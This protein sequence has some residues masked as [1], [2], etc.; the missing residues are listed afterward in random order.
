M[1]SCVGTIAD[2][3]ALSSLTLNK[4]NQNA[5]DSFKGLLSATA[6]SHD[7]IEL[8]FDAAAGD[9]ESLSYEIYVNNSSL[10][11]RV[12]GSSLVNSKT[13]DGSYIFTVTGTFF[14]NKI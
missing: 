3:N 5:N 2:K 9:P 11:I 12:S 7:K 13:I 10:P 1:S 6:V 4:N 8:V 14:K